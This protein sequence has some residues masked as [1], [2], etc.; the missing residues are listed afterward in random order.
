MTIIPFPKPANGAVTSNDDVAGAVGAFRT[1][2]ADIITQEAIHLL[3]ECL[4]SAGFKVFPLEDSNLSK[5]AALVIEAVRSLLL[6]HNGVPHQFQ[7][8]AGAIF[9]IDEGSGEVYFTAVNES[10]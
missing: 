10:P 9:R 4:D 5:D 8:V 3:F 1:K 2:H 7:E 6:K